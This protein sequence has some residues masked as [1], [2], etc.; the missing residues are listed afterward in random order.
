MM[1]NSLEKSLNKIYENLAILSPET[2]TFCG[3]SFSVKQLAGRFDPQTPISSMDSMVNL[4]QNTLY[5]YAYSQAFKSLL[6]DLAEDYDLALMQDFVVQLSQA[7]TSTEYWDDGWQIIEV[8]QAAQIV[9][10]KG[11]ILR[12]VMPG[13]YLNLDGIGSIPRI[14]GLIRLF[15]P[16]ESTT[17]QPGFYFVFGETPERRFQTQSVARYYFDLVLEGALLFVKTTTERL[18]QF[19]IPFRLKCVSHPQIFAKRLD[20]GVVFVNRRFHRIMSEL[21]F[22]VYQEVRPFL[23]PETPLFTYEIA[24]GLA[25]A[26]DP[27]NGESF[28]ISRCRVVAEGIWQA[29]LEGQQSVAARAMAVKERFTAHELSFAKPYLNPQSPYD[30][31]FPSFE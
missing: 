19:Q 3:R 2:I 6:P 23:Q 21:I 16:R 27:A 15:F 30:Y 4:L 18:N 14:G 25:F 13:E 17:F 7:N 9:A 29:Y 20:S 26:E 5:Q 1:Q 24:P 12:Q 31:C 10:Q 8:G 11:S 28:G 22:D